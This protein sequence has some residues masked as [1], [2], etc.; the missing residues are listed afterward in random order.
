MGRRNIEIPQGKRSWQYRF[1]EILPAFLSYS[2]VILMA[3]LSVFSPLLASVYL[4]LIVAA[5]LVKSFGIGY[6][7]LTG[8]HILTKAIRVDWRA[9]LNDLSRAKERFEELRAEKISNR[10]EFEIVEHRKNLCRIAANPQD[11]PL[12]QDIFNAVIIAAYNEPYEVIEPT[13]QSVLASNYDSSNLM[14][15]LAYEER[16]GAEIEKTA[17]RLKK[18]FEGKF[19][20]FEIVKHPRNIKGEVVGKGGNITFAG[21][22]LAEFCAE[23]KIPASNVL[24]TT[25]DSDNKPHREY[26][27]AA[28]YQFIV[29]RERKH[30]SYQPVSLFLNNIW[31]APAP[32]RVIATGNSFW[33]VVSSMRPHTLRNFASHSQPLDALIEMDFWSVRTIVEDGHQFWRSY[34]HFEGKYD[35][36]PI[37]VPI[38]QDAVLSETLPKTLKAQFVQLRRWMYGASDVPYVASHI[39]TRQRKVPFFDAFYKFCQLLGGHVN[40][41]YQAPLTAFG[42]WIP[43]LL[44]AY[45][46]RSMVAHQLPNVISMIQQ[47]A[48]VGLFVSIFVSLKML[49]PKPERYK[50]SRT[51][52]MVL[53]WLL[54]PLTSLIYGS[55]AAAYAQ[56]RLAS[57]WYL[58]KFDVTQKGTVA[59][60]DR[61]RAERK[62]KRSKK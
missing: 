48:I 3:V 40:M 60:I 37:M 45:A 10:K 27:S 35:V 5:L 19:R 33:N 2:A 53:Q 28:T 57:G 39:F 12:P 52:F 38:Y 46:S 41:V 7:T 4:L 25:L 49:P 50:R 22:R 43:L 9:R 30:L 31:D 55:A 23:Q 17:K 42:G 32:I 34:F 21:R 18:E 54:M 51:I 13:I 56:F 24:V 58:D 20:A 16:G 44:N 61:A 26:F 1:F 47:I 14:I 11:Y 29:N 6:R 59:D 36:V 15:F 62:K 8:Y